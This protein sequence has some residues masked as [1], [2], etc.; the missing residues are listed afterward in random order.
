MYKYSYDAG[1]IRLTKDWGGGVKKS[2]SGL[3]YP[4][5]LTR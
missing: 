5:I 2:W 3:R 4:S 1:R